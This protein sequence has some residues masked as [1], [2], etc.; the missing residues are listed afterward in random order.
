MFL[1]LLYFYYECYATS[2][3]DGTSGNDFNAASSNPPSASNPFSSTVP[4]SNP[5]DPFSASTVVPPPATNPIGAPPQNTTSPF[6]GFGA[7]PPATGG[8]G[9]QVTA[10]E[11][12]DGFG[13]D[14]PLAS[15][16]LD[17]TVDLSDSPMAASAFPPENTPA[18]SPIQCPVC[19]DSREHI[20]L[21]GRKLMSTV[22]GHIFCSAC[23]PTCIKENGRCPT[24]RKRV[25]QNDVITLHI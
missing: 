1:F 17:T 3:E 4:P 6:G 13:A 20:L 5:S 9:N 18:T 22:C 12:F 10:V 16:A 14:S 25:C 11:G 24:C 2:G 19:L 23:L 7:S 15:P 8:F 21:S